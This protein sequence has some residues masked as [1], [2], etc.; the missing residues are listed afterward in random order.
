MVYLNCIVYGIIYKIKMK[1]FLLVEHGGKLKDFT[2]K[3]AL[4]KDLR[5]FLVTNTVEDWLFSYFKKEDVIVVDT[6]NI[7]ELIGAVSFFMHNKNIKFDGVGT[8]FEHFVTQ[9]SELAEVLGLVGLPVKASYKSS[10]NKLLMRQRCKQSGISQPY[11]D[12]FNLDNPVVVSS[13]LEKYS[14]AVIKPLYGGSSVGVFKIDQKS[15]LEEV[16]ETIRKEMEIEPDNAFKDYSSGFLLEEYI[17]GEM[18]SMDGLVQ[19][20]VIHFI[21]STQFYLGKEPRFVQEGGHTPANLDRDTIASCKKIVSDIVTSLGFDNCGFHCELRLSLRGPLLVEIAARLP[22]GPIQGNYK[23]SS[24]I[25]STSAMYD[26]W[27]GKPLSIKKKANQ[28]VRHKVVYADTNGAISNIDF[29][30]EL[31]AGD[32]LVEFLM[33]VKEGDQCFTYP[34][35]PTALYYY[36]VH[37]NSY[38]DVLRESATIESDVQISIL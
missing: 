7:T 4:E 16:F 33:F 27:L 19:G 29:P 14:Q 28:V 37:G 1:N 22:G 10:R 21:G 25:D 3:T 20:K 35:S 38:E 6:N 24:G 23:V 5:L 11:F 36:S 8:F 30:K 17:E 13:F 9:T 26:I 34:L 18:I 12:V 32:H 15:D 2:L 31:S